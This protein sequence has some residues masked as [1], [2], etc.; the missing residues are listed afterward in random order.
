MPPA[1]PCLH[2]AI[3]Y[4]YGILN[5]GMEVFRR[6][7]LKVVVVRVQSANNILENNQL[8]VFPNIWPPRD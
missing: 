7:V 4:F 3:P 8:T 6:F 5:H 1:F 2:A